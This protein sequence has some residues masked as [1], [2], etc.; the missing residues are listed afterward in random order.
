MNPHPYSLVTLPTHAWSGF[1]SL[2]STALLVF[3]LASATTVKAQQQGWSA[4]GSLGTAR[5]GH[6]ATLLENGKVLVVGGDNKGGVL[7]GAEIY[8]PATGQWSATGSP[9][10]P[11][12][13]HIAVRLANGKVL[14]AGGTY[15]TTTEIYDPDTGVWSAAGNLSVGRQAPGATLL[16][17]GKVLVIGGAS[18]NSADLYDPATGA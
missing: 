2:V 17:D 10:T 14:V 12:S 6:T 11:R 5:G 13:S 3:L 9:S 18:V 7:D 15:L 16:A 8:D 4:T 1:V